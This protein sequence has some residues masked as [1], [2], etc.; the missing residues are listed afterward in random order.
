MIKRLLVTI[1]LFSEACQNIERK[2]KIMQ[3]YPDGN[4]KT[5]ITYFNANDT[6]KFLVKEFLENG[7]LYHEATV[8]NGEFI[9]KK[10][11]YYQDKTVAQIDSLFV[12][13]SVG[14]KNWTG[15]VIRFYPTG[16]MSQRYFVK[17]GEM[18]GLFQNYKKDG[19]I[20]KEYEVSGDSIKNGSYT[21]YHSNGVKS[22]QTTYAFGKHQGMEYYFDLSGDTT[23]YGLFMDGHYKFPY[24]K[25]LKNGMVLIGNYSN[26]QE[27]QVIWLWIDKSG[28]KVKT[29]TV[30]SAKHEFS[31]PK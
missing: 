20:S 15:M 10:I 26:P 30:Y 27:T 16:V 2:N 25:W 12:P 3:R 17:N 29:K 11:K 9:G 24:K 18:T 13:E 21:E 14:S 31:I 8:N 4:T 6:T 7:S 23:E 1:W 28:R 19:I 5:L 22:Y